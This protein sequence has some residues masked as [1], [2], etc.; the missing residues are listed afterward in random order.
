LTGNVTTHI[1]QNNT[2]WI[3]RHFCQKFTRVLHSL[4]VALIEA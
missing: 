3:F 1:P 2:N 4:D